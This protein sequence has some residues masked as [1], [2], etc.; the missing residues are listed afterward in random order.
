[1]T[2]ERS[3]HVRFTDS[4]GTTWTVRR[5]ERREAVVPIQT[6]VPT[7][8][9]VTVLVFD[10]PSVQRAIADYPSNWQSLSVME[11]EALCSRARVQAR[12]I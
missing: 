6:R 9:R 7:L 1:M 2:R 11:L 3:R 12:R 4:R 5:A 8:E 10:S